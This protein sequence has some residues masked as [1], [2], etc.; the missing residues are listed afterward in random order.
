MQLVSCPTRWSLYCSLALCIDH[1]VGGGNPIWAAVKYSD[2]CWGLDWSIWTNFFAK[3]KFYICSY[4]VKKIGAF[5]RCFCPLNWSFFRGG[6]FFQNWG[7]GPSILEMG[8]FTNAFSLAPS[9]ELFHW[10]FCMISHCLW[11]IYIR[12]CSFH[13]SDTN[14]T[15]FTWIGIFIIWIDSLSRSQMALL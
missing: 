3:C 6:A 10:I 8:S 5:S 2:H 12:L 11:S 1:L 7:D 4:G 15:T 14:M 13:F 9:F